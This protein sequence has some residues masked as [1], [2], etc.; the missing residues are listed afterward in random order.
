MQSS[1]ILTLLIFQI[2]MKDSLEA[3]SADHHFLAYNSQPVYVISGM[4]S[5]TNIEKEK[6]AASQEVISRTSESIG[7]NPND[8]FIININTHVQTF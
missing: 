4:E 2:K 6:E 5:S 3:M 1:Q 7:W 8:R